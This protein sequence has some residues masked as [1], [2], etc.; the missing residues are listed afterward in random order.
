MSLKAPFTSYKSTDDHDRLICCSLPDAKLTDFGP[1]K[2]QCSVPPEFPIEHGGISG[3]V[4]MHTPVTWSPCLQGTTYSMF[5]PL[6]ASVAYMRRSEC[7][8]DGQRRVYATH[9]KC[10]VYT[11]HHDECSNFCNSL[12]RQ[13]ILTNDASLERYWTQLSTN[14]TI[15]A[16]G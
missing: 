8:L 12:K 15:F 14:G 11:A 6:H 5:N 16:I 2:L 3:P 4:L 13:E 9:P 1:R 7:I 10:T